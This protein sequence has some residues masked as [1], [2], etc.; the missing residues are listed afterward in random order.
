[1]VSFF[2]QNNTAEG[3]YLI[4]NGVS[5]SARNFG[6]ILTFNDEKT[7]A[8]S[9]WN[10]PAAAVINGTDGSVFHPYIEK[11]ER[12]EV[13]V[14]N[15]CRSIYLTFKEEVEYKGILA[16]RFVMPAEVLNS[17][18][19]E[20][21]GF[22]NNNEKSYF[23]DGK[24]ECLPAGLLDISRCQKGEPT[25][26]FSLPNFLFADQKVKDG[27]SG[28]NA[29]DL[30]R[31]QISVDIEP[32]L[33]VILRANRTSQINVAMWKGKGI[34]F[35]VDLTQ[36]KSSIVPVVATY[37]SV[38]VDD[39]TLQMIQERLIRTEKIATTSSYIGIALALIFALLAGAV[40]LYLTGKLENLL[41]R[42]SV[43][44]YQ[45]GKAK[46]AELEL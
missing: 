25:I 10:S 35:P 45:N 44:P 38:E 21:R 23:T 42:D 27:V 15:L 32:R 46:H 24:E 34:N 29:S 22:C 8:S 37:E 18:L 16:Y 31:D 41:C 33:G 43:S 26:V 30:S 20:N 1:L 39:G 14:S 13:F 12:L 6:K 9:V 19:P 5:N 28:I 17:S 36:F 11:T 40:L 2:K 3:T 7:V 4:D